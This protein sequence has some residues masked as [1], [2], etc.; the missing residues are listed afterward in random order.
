MDTVERHLPGPLRAVVTRAR[1]EDI[2]LFSASLAFY[3][4]VSVIPLAILLMWI[5]S[6]ALGDGR[7]VE[8]A[9]QLGRSAPK[10]I[11]VDQALRRVAEIGTGIGWVSILTALW[12]A[13]AYGAGLERAFQRLSPRRDEKF[14]GLRG[15]A[16][17]LLFLLP[18]LI[19]GSLLA[20]YVGTTVLGKGVVN[21]ALG[22]A[23]ALVTG[24]L[25]ASVGTVLVFRI[26][27]Q[28]HLGWKSIARGTAVTA[29]GVSVLSV[30]L[31]L[32]L[33]SGADFEEHYATSGLAGLVLLAVWLFL[34]NAMLLVG[35]KVAIE[36]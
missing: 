34:S 2:L 28:E 36:D 25:G 14:P 16:L 20:S 33:V 29:A 23:V 15:R 10:N 4:F 21:T 18:L 30:V 1:R 26:F 22:W 3:A 9:A 12:P 27:P 31:V 19:L 8:L 13:T 7:V 5:A 32:F 6:L 24:F 11:G 35:Y 17:L